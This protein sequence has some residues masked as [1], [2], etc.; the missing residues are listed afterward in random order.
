MPRRA[1][2]HAVA[3]AVAGAL[4]LGACTS[5]PP[6]PAPPAPVESSSDTG[7]TASAD[8]LR[9]PQDAGP[10]PS[11]TADG[12]AAPSVWPPSE[13]TGSGIA[14]SATPTL[15]PRDAEGPLTFE[16]YDLSAGQEPGK[17]D[18]IA[19]GTDR[20]SWVTS[21]LED[22]RQY[23]WRVREKDAAQWKGPWTFDIDTVRP[24]LAPRDDIGGV[25][26][27]LITGVPGI[28]WTSRSFAT[29]S[30]SAF[31]SMEFQPGRAGDPGLP[32]GWRMAAP[33]VSRWTTLEATGDP[34]PVSVYI[35]DARDRSM[36]FRLNDS[37]VYVQS[38]AS[39]APL[40]PSE[41][42]TLTYA[43][44]RFELT[45]RD[46]TVTQFRDGFPVSVSEDGLL[47]GTATWSPEGLLTSVSDPS[48]RTIAFEYGCG[49]KAWEGFVA[50]PADGLCRIGWWDGTTTEIGYV[51][52]AETAQIGL[53]VDAIGP[54]FAG[55]SLGIGW[56]RS[57]RVSTL[58]SAIAGAAAAADPSLRDDVDLLTEIV[59]D[60]QGRVA[61]V[62]APAPAPGAPR[63]AHVFDYPVITDSESASGA[64]V[65]ASVIAG[66]V[67]GSLTEASSVDPVSSRLPGSA[68]YRMSVSA[69]DWV[70]QQRDDRDGS[71]I[72]LRWDPRTQRLEGMTDY[73][74]RSM[75]FTYDD[76]GRRTG[77]VGP[78]RQ[79]DAAYVSTATFDEDASG[80]PMRGVEAVYWASAD[81]SGAD[82]T[83]GWIE[84]LSH[85]WDEAPIPGKAWSA[86]LTGSWTVPEAGTWRLRPTVSADGGIDVY[87]DNRL[88]DTTTKDE[89]ELELKEGPHQLRID[90]RNPQGGRAAFTLDASRGD[91]RFDTLSGVTPGFNVETRTVSNDVLPRGGR[92]VVRT[93][94][95]EPWTGNPTSL[96]AP[97]GLTT[98]ATYEPTSS[99][100][101]KWGRK[102][103]GT[104]PGGRTTSTTYWPVQGGAEASPCPGSVAAVQAGLVRTVTRTDGVT[105]STWYDAA[106]RPTAILTG[107]GASGDL[108]C[109]TYAPDGTP[110][111]ASL[112]A[113]GTAVEKS[114]ATIAVGGD[115]RVTTTTVEVQGSEAIGTRTS[116]TATDLLGRLV[117]Y[118]D[119]NGVTTEFTYDVFD[120]QVGRTITDP[121]G[122]TLVKVSRA[123]DDATGREVS[124]TVN[125][126]EAAAVEYD[127]RG[128]VSRVSYGSGVVQDWGYGPNG[129]VQAT[130]L[131]T[132][133]ERVVSDQV[134]TNSAGRADERVTEVEG[135]GATRRKWSYAYDEARRL[136]GAEL[137]VKGSIAGVGSEERFFS[138]GFGSPSGDCGGAYPDPGG[139]LNRTSGSRDGTDYVTCYD[140]A[141]RPVSTTDPLIAGEGKAELAW[142]ALG[143]LTSASS[144]ARQLTVEWHWGGLPRALIDGAVVSEL[145]HAQ[146]R[147][148]VQSSK[149]DSTSVT[150]RLGYSSP[151]ATAASVV[152]SDDGAEVR[153]LLPGG[154]LWRSAGAVTVDHPGIRGEYLVTTDAKGAVVPG[155]EGGV[156][157]EALGPFGEPM[158]GGGRPGGREYGY[159]FAQ[160]DPTLP[161]PSGIVLKTARPYLPA[162]G[163]FIAFDPQPGSSTTGY[164]YAEADPLNK[165][166]PEGAYT[167]WDFGR[168]V[169][170]V[171]S[172]AVSIALPGAQW[173][174]V[175]AVS[176]L[177]SSTSLGITALERAANGQALTGS[178]VVF[179]GISVATDVLMLGIGEAAGAV[180]RKLSK[181]AKAA[182]QVLDDIDARPALQASNLE[183]PAKKPSWKE[184][185]VKATVIVT[186]MRGITGGFSSGQPPADLP[187][188]QGATDPG[189]CPFP[190]GCASIPDRNGGS[191]DSLM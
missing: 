133:D 35:A 189:S 131:K 120:R 112:I 87:V 126:Q 168:D 38:W 118:T 40:P 69:D 181:P 15:R 34:T 80:D 55:T 141:G 2:H 74:G 190:G 79:E 42:P 119:L 17:G 89:C 140:G 191:G 155:A 1:V 159:A 109:T 70:P 44:G 21:P 12:P 45:E 56:D 6:S 25:S 84:E 161:G 164:G 111:S 60:E 72:S 182:G 18:P 151:E 105:V 78:S 91:G 171:A 124:V 162:L 98:T 61:A 24:G 82:T 157:S 184:A 48:G 148:V 51:A 8:G 20:D 59:Y 176:V 5:A 95:A 54:D 67:T 137:T 143:R 23:A 93:S 31:A 129:T 179:E 14:V 177:T 180:S 132:S 114:S 97:G 115:P 160:L 134:T 154:A 94:Y 65:V 185:V 53:I 62:A 150:W 88:C 147:V 110:I 64:T 63:L 43:E 136:T 116:R 125:G 81:F 121:D 26:T 183:Q 13:L 188:G 103:T 117:A 85:S 178:D 156:L 16:V 66:T 135:E 11:S 130:V 138:Y 149:D 175:L 186:A 49:G 9:P 22:G 187:A 174:T 100:D 19:E 144:N 108:A 58:R 29:V 123:F 128:L 47:K 73:E 83:G 122:K 86:R 92:P 71:T 167:W 41:Q 172:M 169:L 104:T 127:A 27:H 101:D 96:T 90:I 139:D 106:G 33:L 28:T 7:E 68:D 145:G 102:L 37:G 30:T 107:E 46:G 153:V 50:P 52:L 142:D 158:A 165:S 3:L 146:G 163:A 99:A 173:Y 10:L 166:D 4:V 39:G 32:P 152:L 36:T 76:E 75:A 170:A 113:G 77:S 57:G